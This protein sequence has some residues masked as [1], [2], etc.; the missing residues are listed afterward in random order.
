MPPVRWSVLPNCYVHVADVPAR[1]E[2]GAGEINF[3]QI[4]QAMRE[5]GYDGIVG[6]EALPQGDPYEAMD[7]FR[8]IFS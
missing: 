5:V 1:L 3:P 7:R 4:A 8:E 6:L 2:L